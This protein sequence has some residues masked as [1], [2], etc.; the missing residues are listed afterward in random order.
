MIIGKLIPA[1]TGLKRYRRIEIEPTEP[2]PRG[3]RRPRPA[4]R[5]RD[6][7]RAR[8]RRRRGPGRRLRPS[9]RPTSLRSRRS[10]PATATRVRRGAGR[11]RRPRGGPGSR[12]EISRTTL[13]GRAGGRPGSALR[14]REPRAS[15][16]GNEAPRPTRR[17]SRP[18][19]PSG[20]HAVLVAMT[21]GRLT[22]RSLLATA[23]ASALGGLLRPA[24]ALSALAGTPG[25]ALA[26]LPPSARSASACTRFGW[27]PT[28]T[29]WACNGRRSAMRTR[30]CASSGRAAASARGSRPAAAGTLLTASASAIAPV[31]EPI[32]T[33]GAASSSCASAARCT[34]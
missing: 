7:R 3:D 1:A 12:E 21:A 34:A 4:R 33:G 27:P 25:T 17:S 22:R 16:A 29:C 26:E 30:K 14:T 11:A 10:A 23:G 15:R 2:L 5:G 6:R 32:W 8:A 31:G 18:A 28:P 13:P 20:R 9:S 19:H 24:G